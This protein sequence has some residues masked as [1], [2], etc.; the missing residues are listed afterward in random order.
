[1]FIVIMRGWPYDN[2]DEVICLN[3]FHLRKLRALRVFTFGYVYNEIQIQ[4][5][6]LW[7]I[8][9]VPE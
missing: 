2:N 3:I 9:M 5:F 1:M 8:K 4:N 7:K 6:A